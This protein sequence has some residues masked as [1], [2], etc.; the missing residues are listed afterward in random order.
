M[1]SVSA[2]S[3]VIDMILPKY[4]IFTKCQPALV[5]I[6]ELGY[7]DVDVIDPSFPVGSI[8]PLQTTLTRPTII[9]LC[10]IYPFQFFLPFLLDSSRMSNARA[11]A[12]PRRRSLRLIEFVTF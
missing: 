10:L 12:P 8:E 2:F 4:Q 3:L 7:M 11:S 5:D 6:F 9:Q 1:L